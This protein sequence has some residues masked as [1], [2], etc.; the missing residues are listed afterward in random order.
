MKERLAPLV[1]VLRDLPRRL[2]QLPRPTP[3]Q[4][5]RATPVVLLVLAL[6]FFLGRNHDTVD[7][8][9]YSLPEGYVPSPPPSTVPPGAELP[10][11]IGVAGTTSSTVPDNVGNAR[12]RGTVRGPLGGVPGAIVRIERSI[13]GTVQTYDVAT[14]AAGLWDAPGIGGGRYRVRAFLPPTLAQRTAEVFL[15]PAGD[16][17][18]LDLVVEEFSEP[19]A[20]LAA[21]PSPANLNQQ[22]NVAVRVSGRFVDN[23]GFVGVQP[24]PGGTVEVSVSSGWQRV[25]AAGPVFTD[26]GGVAVVTFV[27]RT[28]GVV[29]VNATVRVTP[30]SVPLVLSGSFACIEPIVTTTTPLPGETT[31]TTS[32]GSTSSTTSTTEP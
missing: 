19:S 27:C 26:G 25:T 20:Q 14:D 24:L 7:F 29:Q 6:G 16:E 17:R 3:M 28:V 30:T 5:V 13:M 12:L 9:H 15:L 4:L 23:D 11:L 1:E 10:H 18:E 8:P 21:A 31:T 32:G 2:R 22:V